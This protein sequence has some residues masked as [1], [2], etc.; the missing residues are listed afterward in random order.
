MEIEF[1]TNKVN[2]PEPAPPV[3]RQDAVRRVE[4]DA[5]F[6]N[7]TALEAKLREIPDVRSEKLEQ[8]R[9][10][11]ANVQYPP[12]QVLNSLAALLAINIK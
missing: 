7:T 9:A 6:A 5:S 8:A 1:N 10:L 3:T 11:L 2:K 12:D 4:E